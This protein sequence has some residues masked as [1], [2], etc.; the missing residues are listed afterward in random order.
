M[1]TK[2]SKEMGLLNAVTENKTSEYVS[3]VRIIFYNTSKLIRYSY[4]KECFLMYSDV[5]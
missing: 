3:D 2:E 1:K 5:K 4:Q